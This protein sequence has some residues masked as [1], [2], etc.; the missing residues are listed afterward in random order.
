MKI[1]NRIQTLMKK[2]SKNKKKNKKKAINKLNKKLE[3]QIDIM[4]W[5]KRRQDQVL[6]SEIKIK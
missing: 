4:L 5:E 6:R 2:K 1:G 3:T